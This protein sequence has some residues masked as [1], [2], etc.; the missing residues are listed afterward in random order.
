MIRNLV[1][2]KKTLKL[3][4]VDES[5]SYFEQLREC[6]EMCSHEFKVDCVFAE[7]SEEAIGMIDVEK[8]TVVLVDAYIPDIQNPGFFEKCKDDIVPILVTSDYQ[9][10]ELHETSQK[11]GAQGYLPK[12]ENP[13]EVEMALR[14][15]VELAQPHKIVC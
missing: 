9:L 13:D 1:E 5:P 14:R 15:I 11:W 2:A 7:T 12:S 10:P 4:V 3:V 8:P 6:A